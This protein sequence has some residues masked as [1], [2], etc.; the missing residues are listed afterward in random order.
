MSTTT[1]QARGHGCAAPDFSARLFKRHPVF[2]QTGFGGRPAHV[3]REHLI[4]LRLLGE[5]RRSQNTGSRPRLDHIRRPA[6]GGLG[7][8][9]A[10]VGLHN[11]NALAIGREVLFQS[12]EIAINDRNQR[13]VNDRGTGAFVLANLGM[14]IARQT[15]DRIRRCFSDKLSQL[16]FVGRIEI[17][18][19]QAHGNRFHSGGHKLVDHR[20][21]LR[22]IKCALNPAIA[23]DAF[24]DFQTQRTGHEGGQTVPV[25][26]VDIGPS[27]PAHFEFVPKALGGNQSGSRGGVFD[28]GIRGNGRAMHEALDLGLRVDLMHAADDIFANLIEQREHLGGKQ[29]S[30]VVN[31]NHVGEGSANI[32]ANTHGKAIPYRIVY[33]NGVKTP[34]PSSLPQGAR[35]Q[36]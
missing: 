21:G 23:Q 15:H 16:S 31:Y 27:L 7:A 2:N 26:V 9:N 13:G 19:H 29:P 1:E 18:I 11:Q 33:P 10:A 20:P 24:P 25:R 35:E 3:K 17:G 8:H 30:V 34:H 12:I 4:L 32:K 14:D 36:M 5:T 6:S 28:D 22:R